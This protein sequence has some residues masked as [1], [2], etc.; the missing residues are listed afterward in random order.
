MSYIK[1]WI[2]AVWATKNHEPV[3]KPGVLSEVCHH[4]QSNAKEKGIYIDRINGYD[5]HIHTLMLLKV[6]TALQS[7]CNY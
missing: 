7:K 2:H 3:L 6:I 1:I 4:I 5:E